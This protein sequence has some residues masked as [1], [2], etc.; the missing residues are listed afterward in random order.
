MLSKKW[1]SSILLKIRWSYSI[2]VGR[3]LVGYSTTH[4]NFCFATFSRSLIH[5]VHFSVTVCNVMKKKIIYCTIRISIIGMKSSASSGLVR[6]I[7]TSYSPTVWNCK[8]RPYPSLL[9]MCDVIKM[10]LNIKHGRDFHCFMFVFVNVFVNRIH[11]QYLFRGSN[12]VYIFLHL[13]DTFYTVHI[14][15]VYS[16]NDDC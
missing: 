13:A 10:L 14:V 4:Y 6:R 5:S 7:V 9:N 15:L 16:L 1:N 12:Y 2:M 11:I 8:C 3:L